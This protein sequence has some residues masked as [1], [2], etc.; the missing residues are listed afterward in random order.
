[1]YNKYFFRRLWHKITRFP[2]EVEWKLQRLFR[3]YSDFDVWNCGCRIAEQSLP[4]LRAYRNLNHTGT[5]MKELPKD[6]DP[7]DPWSHE[8]FTVDEWNEILDKVI[9]AFEY[10]ANDGFPKGM[11]VFDKEI[12]EEAQKK[13]EEGMALFAKWSAG[14]WD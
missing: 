7:S 5:P 10:T 9:F 6:A 11:E 4:L 14:M 1:M 3:G 8:A 2:Y 13:Y 12:W